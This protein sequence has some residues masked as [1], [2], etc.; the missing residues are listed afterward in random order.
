MLGLGSYRYEECVLLQCLLFPYYFYYVV[1][2]LNTDGNGNKLLC[3]HYTLCTLLLS[4]LG[5]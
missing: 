1:S 4:V 3:M 5:T 2:Q